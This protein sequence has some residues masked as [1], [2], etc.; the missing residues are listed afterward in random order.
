MRWKFKAE[1]GDSE[2]SS[3]SDILEVLLER[4][5]RIVRDRKILAE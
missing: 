3:G 2:L 5:V 1:F 4:K